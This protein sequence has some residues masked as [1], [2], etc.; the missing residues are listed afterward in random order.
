MIIEQDSAVERGWVSAGE[1]LTYYEVEGTGETVG[2]T[3]WRLCHRGH[4]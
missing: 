2:N 1:L 3:A 4:L